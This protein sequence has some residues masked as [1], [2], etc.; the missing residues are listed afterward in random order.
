MRKTLI[1]AGAAAAIL[2]MM[3]GCQSGT[4]I[5]VST[6]TAVGI[7]ATMV[8]QYQPPKVKLGYARGEV[9]I[10]PTNRDKS[11]AKDSFGAG[12]QDSADVIMTMDI[13]NLFNFTDKLISQKLLIGRNAMDHVDAVFGRTVPAEDIVIP[14][15]VV[16]NPT[17]PAAAPAIPAVAVPVPA[18]K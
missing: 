15:V 16:A 9:T 13:A 6:A 2:L 7:E 4:S 18:T 17:M 8:D 11:W 10:I 1:T 12:A 14:Q 5:V 3:A